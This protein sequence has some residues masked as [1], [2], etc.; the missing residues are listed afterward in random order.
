MLWKIF[1]PM[2][3]PHKNKQKTKI[4]K[5]VT[6]LGDTLTGSN[7]ISNEFNQYFAS[8]GKKLCSKIKSNFFL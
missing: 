4:S 6:Y 5:L 2:I 1:G 3:N 7:E 8:V